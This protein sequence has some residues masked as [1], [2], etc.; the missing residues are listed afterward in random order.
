MSDAVS[1]KAGAISAVVLAAGLARRMGRDKLMLTLSEEPVIRHVVEE[2][3]SV[4]FFETIVV[5]NP[6]N[7]DA[8]RKTL[9]DLLVRIVHNERFQEGMAS[10]IVAG[11]AA[12]DSAS[13]GVML[14]QGDQPLVDAEIL[15]SLIDA[16]DGNHP[17]FVAASFDG[18]VTTPVLF[19][20]VLLPE[21]KSLSGDVGARS[22][23][24]RHDGRVIGFE[25][26]RGSD[27][28]TDEDYEKVKR[29]FTEVRSR[30]LA[31]SDR[32]EKEK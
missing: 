24:K 30:R 8:I 21:L 22:V 16:W 25:G 6:N 23:L 19:G 10:S 13:M 20:R 27:V 5:V 7:N 31:A 15:R 2:A 26:W 28:D 12:V 29:I 1:P 14:V 3:L 18:V 9:A 4:R 32:G 17:E 11:V